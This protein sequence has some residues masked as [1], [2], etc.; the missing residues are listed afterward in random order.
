MRLQKSSTP[1]Q[2][3]FEVGSSAS[4]SGA[5]RPKESASFRRDCSPPLSTALS[6]A[7]PRRPKRLSS[8]AEGPPPCDSFPASCSK[9]ATGQRRV[10]RPS[11][12]AR[13]PARMASSV[14]FP[15]PFGPTRPILSPA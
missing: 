15:L 14:D 11:S 9:K 13:R 7:R 3:R 2:S 12:G 10:T 5:R 1:S 8:S 4:S 6:A